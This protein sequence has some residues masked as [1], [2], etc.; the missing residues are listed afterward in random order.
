MNKS[1]IRKTSSPYDVE[2]KV[3]SFHWW[4][5][6]KRRLLKFLLSSINIPKNRLIIDAGCGTGSNLRALASWGYNVIGLDRS[7]YALSLVRTKGNFPLLSGDLNRLPIKMKS[8]GIIIALDILEHLESDSNGIRES[9]RAL[10]QG[11]ILILTVPAFKSLWGI[12]DV[13]T[14]HKRRYLKK[15]I[16]SK[17]KDEGFDI[18]KSSYFNF[19][20]FLPILIARRIIRLIGTEIESENKV[21]IPLLNFFLKAIFSMEPR[22]LRYCSFPFGVSIF[23]IARKR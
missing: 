7:P 15:E 6:G 18:L 21:N 8:V 1:K 19:F 4:F 16:L 3:E 22:I 20:L 12:Q 9:Y 10:R 23:C 11:G 17:L 2:S 5:V 14:G 13:V